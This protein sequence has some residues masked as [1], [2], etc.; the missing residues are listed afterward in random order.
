MANR[1]LEI[2]SRFHEN[3]ETEIRKVFK[4]EECGKA[5][6]EKKYLN[7]HMKTHSVIQCGECENS[8]KN[9]KAFNAHVKT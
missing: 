7:A 4:C 6:K 8:Y 3:E 1:I 2:G 5:F 9:K